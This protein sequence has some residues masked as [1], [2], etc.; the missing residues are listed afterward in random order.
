MNQISIKHRDSWPDPEETYILD[1]EKIKLIVFH[2]TMFFDDDV[3]VYGFVFSDGAPLW[4]CTHFLSSSDTFGFYQWLKVNFDVISL[5][6]EE[7]PPVVVWPAEHAGTTYFEDS[8]VG[9]LTGAFWT[10]PGCYERRKVGKK[11][12]KLITG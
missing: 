5:L 10:F 12:A 8:I 11:I 7:E 1:R 9:S 4:I 2:G 3:D 6:N